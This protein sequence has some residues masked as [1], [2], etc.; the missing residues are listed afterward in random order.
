[1]RRR[2]AKDIQRLHGLSARSLRRY[3]ADLERIGVLA[4][5]ADDRVQ[6]FVR[7]PIG[8]TEDGRL[9]RVIRRRLLKRLADGAGKEASPA[10]RL[11][12]TREWMATPRTLASFSADLAKV[13]AAVDG[14]SAYE[15]RT[16]APSDLEPASLVV[17]LGVPTIALPETA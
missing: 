1:V 17:V 10:T 16:L 13:C 15:G 2:T 8:F 4:C 11:F 14:T 12:L 5:H 3:L 7:E 6:L 9:R